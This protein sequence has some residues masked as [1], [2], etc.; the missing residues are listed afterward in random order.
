MPTIEDIT[1]AVIKDSLENLTVEVTVTTNDGV[2]AV[3]SVP[4]GVSR[5]GTE[6]AFV[7]AP[8]SVEIIDKIIKPKLIGAEIDDQ[9]LIDNTMLKL[10]GSLNKER[11]GA[12]STLAVS[13]ACARAAAKSQSMPLYQYIANRIKTVPSIPQPLMVIIEGGKHGFGNPLTYQEFL[14][15]GKLEEGVKIFEKIKNRFSQEEIR[16][17]NGSEGGIAPFLRTN[18]AALDLLSSVKGTTKLGL[19]IA[20]SHAT[21]EGF[22]LVSLINK[23]EISVVEDP[24]PESNWS[25]WSSLTKSIGKHVM[26]VGDDLITTNIHRL[27]E[28]IKK[29]AANSIIIKPNQIGTLTETL[30][31]V[32][33]AKEV[34]WDLVVS[35]RAGETMDDFIADLAVGIGA[36]LLKSGCPTQK[37][38]L[39]KYERVEAIAK[40]LGK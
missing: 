18:E 32:K 28:A 19:D 9:E 34:G 39:L 8:M 40:E 20:A 13:L 21:Q 1:A 17:N 6:A 38:R 16:W 10:D 33:R 26:I 31:V 35:H 23:Y 12:N 24:F 30:T 15:I 36:K 22:D 14:V 5:G 7:P 25:A 27:E 3:D 4:T 11:F 37:E 2:L 29:Q